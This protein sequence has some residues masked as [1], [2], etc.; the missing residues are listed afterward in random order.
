MQPRAGAKRVNRRLRKWMILRK[1]I[2][3]PSDQL[4][5]LLVGIALPLATAILLQGEVEYRSGGGPPRPQIDS[6]GVKLMKR[7]KHF[8]YFEWTIMIEQYRTRSHPDGRGMRGNSCNEYLRRTARNGGS[9]MMLGH[10]YPLKAQAFGMA[11][12][13]DAVLQSI[14][15]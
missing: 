13:L 11:C 14:M 5:Y 8:R 4:G 15:P 1:A 12:Q 2:V 9:T 10:P 3:E 6:T 7:T